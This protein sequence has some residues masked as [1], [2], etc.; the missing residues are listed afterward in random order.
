MAVEIPRFWAWI[1][2]K[3]PTEFNENEVAFQNRV[4]S[5]TPKKNYNLGVFFSASSALII[6]FT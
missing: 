1:V 5:G 6:V 2:A 3:S 4:N